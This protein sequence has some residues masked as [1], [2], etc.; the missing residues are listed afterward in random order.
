MPTFTVSFKSGSLALSH[1]GN[2]V[3][4]DE[5]GDELA[6]LGHAF[7][8]DGELVWERE[9]VRFSPTSPDEHGP[10]I[11]NGR[12]FVKTASD[13]VVAVD[14]ESGEE[15]WVV[16]RDQGMPASVTGSPVLGGDGETVFTTASTHALAMDAASGEI[17]WQY[18]LPDNSG[19]ASDI[20]VGNDALYLTCDSNDGP[21][22]VGL[23]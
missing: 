14:T 13:G 16:G 8:S 21:L 10:A 6:D 1:N 2:L 11:A 23:A 20:I 22:L 9:D 17:Q 19:R 5:I 7:T 3:N 15:L 4:A 12:M 18:N